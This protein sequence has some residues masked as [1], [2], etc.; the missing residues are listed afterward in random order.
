VTAGEQYRSVRILLSSARAK[1]EEGDR[2]AA[3]KA[4]E[5]ALALDPDFLAAQYLRDRIQLG[6]SPESWQPFVPRRS[7]EAQGAVATNLLDSPVPA[8]DVETTL[9]V[10]H[11]R[12]DDPFLSGVIA[13]QSGSRARANHLHRR[14]VLLPAAAVLSAI[15]LGASWFEHATRLRSRPTV[16]IARLIEPPEERPG[17][18]T[19]PA[20]EAH[21]NGTPSS[22]SA[23][24]IQSTRG[25]PRPTSPRES[26]ALELQRV[27]A[28]VAAEA[29]AGRH[30][31]G[32]QPTDLP[33]SPAPPVVGT[34][35]PAPPT[36][37]PSPADGAPS[38]A[39]SNA[40]ASANDGPGAVP[41]P[42][43]PA[44]NDD[45][46]L[47]QRVLQRYRAAYQVLDARSARE[48]WPAVDEAALS[49]AFHSLESQTL[50]FDECDV[51][52]RGSAGGATCRGTASY[53]P[54]VGSREAR[55][56]RRTWTFVLRKIGAAWV[57][58][59]VKTHR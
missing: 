41:A 10:E 11:L 43:A 58:Q 31:E 13:Y 9:S 55:V 57:I 49:R 44:A 16:S 59:S 23:D 56:E 1:L 37:A 5:D 27:R 17:P 7:P 50:S 30:D 36:R 22:A 29:L 52:V 21:L 26:V 38:F 35:G 48:V 4:L 14:D 19:T 28:I 8:T 51:R 40:V 32:G 25:A 46:M 54:K 34:V 24:R 15:V 18:A 3:L 53:V 47:I 42:A 6:Q 33:T 2:A 45:E 20:F 12:Y 39:G